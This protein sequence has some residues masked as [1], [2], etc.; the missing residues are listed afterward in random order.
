M[1]NKHID[2]RGPIIQALEKARKLAPQWPVSFP[3]TEGSF[4][5]FKAYPRPQTTIIIIYLFLFIDGN[6]KK[7]ASR[8]DWRGHISVNIL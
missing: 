3:N 8:L 7:Y 5:G 6:Y 4:I 1:Y 2:N